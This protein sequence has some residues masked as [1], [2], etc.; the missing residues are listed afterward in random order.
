[1]LTSEQAV[2]RIAWLKR[3]WYPQV[4]Q[5]LFDGFH[6]PLDS[7]FTAF[8]P[9]CSVAFSIWWTLLPFP[10]SLFPTHSL[11]NRAMTS[12]TAHLVVS[13]WSPL[14]LLYRKC[15]SGCQT[16]SKE[17]VSTSRYGG[18]R[19]SS[20]CA[21]SDS[22]RNVLIKIM[23]GSIALRNVGKKMCK[24]PRHRATSISTHFVISTAYRLLSWKGSLSFY[25]C[26]N[27]LL[28]H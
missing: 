25:A 23:P 26:V 14:C 28:W 5:A 20:A 27:T 18:L 16:V 13:C 10:S 2:W 19:S 6:N 3:L 17:A 9:M 1:M 24:A 12:Y 8:A 15:C 4:Q 21:R 22:H 11:H 7:C